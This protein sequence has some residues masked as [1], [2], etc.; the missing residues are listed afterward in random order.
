MSEA[1]Q[2]Q[3]PQQTFT[4]EQEEVKREN[5]LRAHPALRWKAIMSAIEIGEAIRPPHLRRNRPRLPH[6]S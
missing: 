5:Y 6:Q 1:D 2:K 3:E 4:K